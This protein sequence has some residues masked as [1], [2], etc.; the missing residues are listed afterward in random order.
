MRRS[1]IHQPRADELP[2]DRK[3]PDGPKR[4]LRRRLQ[5]PNLLARVVPTDPRVG[6]SALSLQG[7]R[8]HD[9]F[10]LSHLLPPVVA[11][12]LGQRRPS[13]RKYGDP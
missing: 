4:D 9:R 13:S 7:V 6:H 1:R 10:D 12:F 8:K 11:M 3:A 2:G 5:T